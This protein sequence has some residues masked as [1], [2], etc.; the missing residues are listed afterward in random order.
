MKGYLLTYKSYRKTVTDAALP[1]K[2]TW[3]QKNFGCPHQPKPVEITQECIVTGS[4]L[5]FRQ[6]KCA[7][8]TRGIHFSLSFKP[9]I[10]I[11]C[12]YNFVRKIWPENTYTFVLVYNALLIQTDT[13]KCSTRSC[14]VSAVENNEKLNITQHKYAITACVSGESGLDLM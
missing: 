8:L 1:H 12:F 7:N 10:T 11:R 9:R 14:D 2:P 5:H 3:S 4:F 6:N 13:L